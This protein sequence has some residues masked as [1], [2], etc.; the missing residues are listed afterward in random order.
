MS[1]IWSQ[2]PHGPA[3]T[4]LRCRSR[5]NGSHETTRSPTARLQ[6]TSVQQV[7]FFIFSNRAWARRFTGLSSQCL[8]WPCCVI[9]RPVNHRHRAPFP[10]ILIQFGRE[11]SKPRSPL[12]HHFC[13]HLHFIYWCQR[14]TH[15]A[16]HDAWGQCHQ[17]HLIYKREQ[18]LGNA[19]KT[20]WQLFTTCWGFSDC[21]PF[22]RKAQTSLSFALNNKPACS[23][24]SS[25]LITA[26]DSSICDNYRKHKNVAM[27]HQ[28]RLVMQHRRIYGV[29]LVSK[30]RVFY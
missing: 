16:N 26:V 19:G 15:V 10:N 17:M 1:T 18:V 21:C 24:D 3:T 27:W 22:S 5:G 2:T 7:L 14:F 30:I 11:L 12:I 29:V 28:N 8:K 4:T 6:L 25:L 23:M 20:R 13:V 9:I